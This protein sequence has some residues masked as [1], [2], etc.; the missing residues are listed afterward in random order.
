M[1]M[2]LEQFEL[3]KKCQCKGDPVTCSN[4]SALYTDFL[5]KDINDLMILTAVK[6]NFQMLSTERLLTIF[7]TIC[8]ISP[9]DQGLL[10]SSMQTK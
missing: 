2:S 10:Y 8:P 4:V 6:R 7:S 1:F 3:Y 9:Y 5:L